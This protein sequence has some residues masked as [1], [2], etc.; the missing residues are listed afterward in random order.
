MK[1]II[2]VAAGGKTT[3]LVKEFIQYHNDGVYPILVVSSEAD[4]VQFRSVIERC[5]GLE[6]AEWGMEYYAFKMVENMDQIALAVAKVK[7]RA[8]FVDCPTMK[9]ADREW[10]YQMSR[11]N[12]I[13]TIVTVQANR[14]PNANKPDIKIVD[15]EEYYT[16]DGKTT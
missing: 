2:G 1:V 13:D 10:L 3:E 12:D 6:S 15:Y 7:P 9:I 11:N 14:S 4:R 5:G 8:L 16:G